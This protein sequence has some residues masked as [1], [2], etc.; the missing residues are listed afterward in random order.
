MRRLLKVLSWVLAGLVLLLLSTAL[1]VQWVD[2]NRHRDVV[3]GWLASALGR[4]VVIEERFTVQLFPNARLDIAGLRIGNP[5]GNYRAGFLSIGEVSIALD[6]KAVLSGLVRIREVR[7]DRPVLHLQRSD[8]GHPN[9]RFRPAA[10]T[11]ESGRFKVITEQVSVTQAELNFRPRNE[12]YSQRLT[13]ADLEYRLPVSSGGGRVRLLGE[14]NGTSLT[15]EGMLGSIEQLAVGTLNPVEITLK[16]GTTSASVRGSVNNLFGNR[17]LALDI[18]A[19]GE[20]FGDSVGLFFADLAPS[21]D[22]LFAGQI[23]ATGNLVGWPGRGLRVEGLQAALS[24]PQTNMTAEGVI[25]LDPADLKRNGSMVKIRLRADTP[26]IR[27]LV[28]LFGPQLPINANASA[29]GEL[30]GGVGNFGIEQLQVV[31]DGEVLELTSTGRISSVGARTG[32]QLDLQFAAECSALESA[33]EEF[34][35]EVPIKGTATARGK[36]TG[37]RGSYALEEL[38]MAFQGR[39]I[40]LKTSGQITQLGRGGPELN[41]RIEA[42][43]DNVRPI[44]EG[45]GYPMPFDA[46]ARALG[47]LA[48]TPGEF[49][50][51]GLKL[52][53]DNELLTAQVTGEILNLGKNGP[54]LDLA[55][56][57]ESGRVQALAEQFGYPLPV[58]GRAAARGALL[59]K[60]GQIRLRAESL[61]FKGDLI[62]FDALGELWLPRAGSTSTRLEFNAATEDAEALL[63]VLGYRIP[64]IHAARGQGILLES[65]GA[66][67]VEELQFTAEGPALTVSANGAVTRLGLDPEFDLSVS[68]VADDVVEIVRKLDLDLDLETFAGLQISAGTTFR[69]S[70]GE[71]SIDTITGS[72]SGAG[73]QGSFSGNMHSPR[74][75]TLASVTLSV[76][77]DDLNRWAPWLAVASQDALPAE[78]ELSLVGS[79][80]STLPYVF[81]GSVTS[82][83]V[84]ASLNGQLSALSPNSALDA[85]IHIKAGS[86]ADLGRLLGRELS[87]SAALAA[88]FRLA[89][90]EGLAQP[91][92]VDLQIDTSALHAKL[93]AEVP[94]PPK[95]GFP[96]QTAFRS[97]SLAD[98]SQIG[99]PGS[100]PATGPLNFSA[101]ITPTAEGI[102]LDDI[103]LTVMGS[104]TAQSDRPSDL[105]GSL[106]YRPAQG[107][108][109]PVRISGDLQSDH[110]DLA[111]LT[112]TPN[113]EDGPKSSKQAKADA[114]P[115]TLVFSDTPLPLEWIREVE[116]AI[117]YGADSLVIPHL[118][119]EEV[120]AHLLVDQDRLRVE[121][122]TGRVAAG[123]FFL[124]LGLDGRSD[125]FESNLV[126][127]ID[128]LQVDQLPGIKDKRLNLKASID[129]DLAL[130]GTG[131]SPHQILSDSNGHAYFGISEGRIPASG[132]QLFTGS[133]FREIL[134][135]MNPLKKD[136][137]FQ[138][139]QCGSIG[140][141][142]VD[143]VAISRGS[144]VIQTPEVLHEIRGGVRFRDEALL[145][146]LMPHARKGI[147]ISAASV[148][149]PLRLGGTLRHP[150]TEV[151]EQGLFKTLAFGIGSGGV[152][153]V[154][155]GLTNRFIKG[156]GGCERAKGAYAELLEQPPEILQDSIKF[157]MNESTTVKE[158]PKDDR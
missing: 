26:S 28:A 102:Q 7:V 10:S 89:R 72:L 149:N 131:P 95:A 136:K 25:E 48:G 63:A 65:S 105:R 121:T 8:T 127:K 52:D 41:V 106:T 66:Y 71:L 46:P 104:G 30:V 42:T 19:S 145:L 31:V 148:F 49:R 112:G 108:K 146:A 40:A 129:M 158:K 21:I 69:R 94:L 124:K 150:V 107:P 3:A 96:I 126:L 6:M 139:I 1:V 38:S 116:I 84:D 142:I 68:A 134:H 93:S 51:E 61:S 88:T 59:G 24:A 119:V 80:D 100:L 37:G 92:A 32:P 153:F 60:P 91:L 27:E 62:S 12:K 143:G 15:L 29:S 39:H 23:Q 137:D 114:T 128:G 83:E 85:V 79:D 58:D 117:D 45:L 77:V 18:E 87:E 115:K 9:W 47:V 130:A 22:A 135:A 43:S 76:R 157:G 16:A 110:F 140:F 4:S 2:W 53:M 54:E 120:R 154:I 111:R 33:L 109:H 35:L 133:L 97:E 20:H 155:E 90:N 78:F 118:P 123:D 125:T 14:L 13:I 73:L 74:A 151:D 17:S 156:K 36:L 147:G 67:S 132:L 138:E 144:I 34:G 5:E 81:L 64:V 152:F 82:G 44:V 57:L 11:G 99:L 86:I 75:P 101:R 141:R 56:D 55:F 122:R 113:P 50:F 70:K 98:L 103:Q